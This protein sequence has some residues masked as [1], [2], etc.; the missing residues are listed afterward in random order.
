MGVKGQN[1]FLII[2]DLPLNNNS[3]IYLIDPLRARILP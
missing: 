2:D 1:N 3:W